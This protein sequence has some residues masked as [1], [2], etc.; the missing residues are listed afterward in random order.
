MQSVLAL[1][2]ELSLSCPMVALHESSLQLA[3]GR[4]AAVALS[5]TEAAAAGEPVS[6][7]DLTNGRKKRA[8]HFRWVHPPLK[9]EHPLSCSHLLSESEPYDCMRHECPC[10]RALS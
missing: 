5:S 2:K 10:E 9:E 4:A 3:V 8:V 7:H 6:V 1:V